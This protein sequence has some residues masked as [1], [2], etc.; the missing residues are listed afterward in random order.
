M[1]SGG[2][3]AGI[4]TMLKQMLEMIS[5]W[6]A[7]DERSA[8]SGS[9][10]TP[11][12]GGQTGRHQDRIDPVGRPRKWS[13]HDRWLRSLAE[14]VAQLRTRDQDVILVSSGAIALGRRHLGLRAGRLKLEESQAAA[15][16]GQIH[17]AKAY[18]DALIDS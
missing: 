12:G 1:I 3:G 17:L 15:A 2:T 18:Q 7:G 9:A 10:M 14:D 4:D 6:R 11:A 16:I 5:A 8:G 13:V